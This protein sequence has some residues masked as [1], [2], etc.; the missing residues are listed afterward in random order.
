MGL[1]YTPLHACDQ[2]MHELKMNYALSCIKC[3]M[4]LVLVIWIQV[5]T[6][7]YKEAMQLNGYIYLASHTVHVHVA[8]VVVNGFCVMLLS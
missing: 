7:C 8:V 6:E 3:M 5:P 1:F 4:L 2:N